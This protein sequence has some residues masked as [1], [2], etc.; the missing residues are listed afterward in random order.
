MLEKY[1]NKITCGDCLEVMKALP[2][3]CVDVVC[4][5]PPYGMNFQSNHRQ[6][7]H[8]AI[9]NDNNLDW[10]PEWCKELARIIKDD[11][12]LYIFC[13]WHKVE[14]FKTELE[15]HIPVKNI[16]IWCK[17]NTGM[18]D[19][20][21]DY[22]PQYEM[23]IFCNPGGRPLNGGRDS[24][25]LRFARTNN[26]FHPT[27]KP[28]NLINYLIRKSLRGGGLVLDTFSGSCPVAIEAHHLKQDFICVEIDE[29]YAAEAQQRLE[30]AKMQLTLF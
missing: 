3:N 21:G 25:L 6:V 28:N 29:K 13:S 10:L 9:Q 2:D 19:L 11:A 30:E 27:Q 15:K 24:V 8:S 23:C 16:L 4:T 18:G 12:H 7:A 1:L 26:E 17:N 22:A 5:D 20:T 14:V